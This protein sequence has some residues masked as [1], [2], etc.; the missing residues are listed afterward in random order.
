M[1]SRR[2]R[3]SLNK[4]FLDIT[5]R[6]KKKGWGGGGGGGGGGG[7]GGDTRRR[8]LR[9][10]DSRDCVIPVICIFFLE[11]LLIKN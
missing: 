9:R 4:N 2:R 6:T 11:L 1:T 7:E 5:K 3:D 8:R 10:S